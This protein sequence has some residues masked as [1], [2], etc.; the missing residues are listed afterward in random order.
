[1]SPESEKKG[2]H[3][4]KDKIDPEKKYLEVEALTTGEVGSLRSN[5]FE[6][7]VMEIEIQELRDEN[8]YLSHS[9]ENNFSNVYIMWDN[10]PPPPC[11][12]EEEII[13]GMGRE[14]HIVCVQ[15]KPRPIPGLPGFYRQK[16]YFF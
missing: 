11:L 7:K 2:I 16:V 6:Q 12:G 8:L 15:Q 1:M 14:M 13:L 3:E 9:Q 10:L 5:D 4:A